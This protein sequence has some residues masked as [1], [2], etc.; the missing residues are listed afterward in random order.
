VAIP[1]RREAEVI[2]LLLLESDIVERYTGGTQEFL[3]RLVDHAA[4]AISNAQLYSAVQQANLAKSDF[5]SLVS[6]ELKTPMTSIKGY[7]DLL[8]AGA[9]GE[10]NEAQANF[11]TTIRSNV[12][13]MSK[14]V[15]DLAD[16][17]RIEA[18]RLYLE[19]GGVPVSVIVD[20]VVTSAQTIIDEK[21]Q[22]LV[23]DISQTLPQVW[24]DRNRLVQV[25]TNLVSNANK[26][27]PEGGDITIKARL[28]ENE[29]DPG[30]A[31]E[32]VHISV[33]D[34]GIGIRE[35]DQA[36][37]FQQY[38]RTEEG[39]ESAPGSGLGLSI[40]RHLVEMQGGKIWFESGLEKGSTFHISIPVIELEAP[41]M[42]EQ[43]QL[44]D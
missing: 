11:L 20:E 3:N 27:T 24:G 21:N 16:V 19:F 2:G 43:F 35:E 36:K 31:A 39:K 28:A 29:W 1:I 42:S 37:I 14:L 23:L 44:E 7:A 12:N 30:G 41:N 26:Y 10:I 32:V 6:H 8:A 40:T 5:V 33:K 13:R 15:S 34:N 9:V 4:I 38:F 17:S 22:N 18:G 25:L